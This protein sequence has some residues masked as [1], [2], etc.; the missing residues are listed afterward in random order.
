MPRG[1]GTG[2]LEKYEAA[3][4]S[5]GGKAK[6]K[7]FGEIK[8]NFSGMGGNSNFKLRENFSDFPPDF[9]AVAMA[10]HM[11]QGCLPSNVSDTASNIEWVCKFEASMV[12]QATVCSAVQCSPVARTSATTTQSFPQR[13]STDKA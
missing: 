9:L 1:G 5:A 13:T 2:G 7:F 10:L 4:R 11:Q 6:V 8:M 3:D 12:A